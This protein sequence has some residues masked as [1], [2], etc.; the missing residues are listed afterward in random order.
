MYVTEFA[1]GILHTHT[2]TRTHAQIHTHAYKHT[3]V[4]EQIK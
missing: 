1:K 3:G 2:H 4:V